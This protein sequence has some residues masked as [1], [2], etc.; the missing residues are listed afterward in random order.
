MSHSQER[1]TV[2]AARITS[3]APVSIEDSFCAA[4]EAAHYSTRPGVNHGMEDADL[5][6]NIAF[7][8]FIPNVSG[9]KACSGD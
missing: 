8:G 3:I 6:C 5:F 7:H 9:C 4:A 2:I 1:C